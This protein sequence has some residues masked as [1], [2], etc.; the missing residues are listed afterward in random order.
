M[1]QYY[2]KKGI[3]RFQ[4]KELR[5]LGRRSCPSGPLGS[6]P[7]SQSFVS[8][9]SRRQSILYH[10]PIFQDLSKKDIVQR[11]LFYSVKTD[12]K[13]MFYYR[14]LQAAYA[15]LAAQAAWAPPREPR[16]GEPQAETPSSRKP[17]VGIY[18][19]RFVSDFEKDFYPRLLP[20]L[21]AKNVEVC[22]RGRSK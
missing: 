11:V 2:N 20:R 10:L 14:L 19:L 7:E 6:A 3:Y 9:E 5:V 18:L 15:F 21:L 13:K 16:V 1:K 12:M 22:S 8:A 17:R 4:K